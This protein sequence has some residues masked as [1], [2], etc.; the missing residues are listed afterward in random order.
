MWDVLLFCIITQLVSSGISH[1]AKANAFLC[2]YPRTIALTKCFKCVFLKKQPQSKMFV[3]KSLHSAG[4]CIL[5]MYSRQL[6]YV[7][8]F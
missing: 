4:A 3:Q 5:N 8:G 2:M 1:T 7:R 6:Y